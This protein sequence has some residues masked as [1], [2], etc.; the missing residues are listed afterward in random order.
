VQDSSILKDLAAKENVYSWSTK[1]DF[2]INIA[3]GFE[4][5]DEGTVCLRWDQ[6]LI[7]TLEKRQIHPNLEAIG[8]FG[9]RLRVDAT[10]TACEAEELGKRVALALLKFAIDRNWGVRLAWTDTPLPCRVID[11]TVS[12]SVSIQGFGSAHERIP[13]DI[14]AEKLGEAFSTLESVP[15]RLLLSMELCAS[16]RFETDERPKLI[17]L[18]SA[19]EALTE[20][21]DLSE[22][23]GAII[24]KLNSVLQDDDTLDESLRA[25]LVGQIKNLKRESTRRAMIRMLKDAKITSNEVSFVED[26]YH[27]RSKIVHEGYRIPELSQMNRKLREIIRKVYKHQISNQ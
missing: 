19:L 6:N 1:V 16:A 18:V 11:R 5:F 22:Y 7:L 24:P 27:A 9:Y 20:Q 13:V 12:S 14:F 8:V 17:L 3:G 4:D 15:Y 25:S 2:E 21:A 10:Q 26:A 23:L